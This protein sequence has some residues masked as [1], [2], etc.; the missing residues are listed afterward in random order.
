[1]LQMSSHDLVL[2]GQQNLEQYM[3]YKLAFVTFSL[4]I[5]LTAQA[6]DQSKTRVSANIKAGKELFRQHCSVCHGTGGKG[7]GSMYDPHSGDKSVR[8]P[9]ADLTLLSERNGGT[10]PVERVK[11]SI[12]S[13]APIQAHGTPSMPAWGDIFYNQK[14]NPKVI[15]ARVRDITAYIESIQMSKR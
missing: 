6:A 9:P 7:D 11:D 1:M 10:F 8:V 12:Q 2:D 14:A 15:S 5:G 3:D 13:K 4:G